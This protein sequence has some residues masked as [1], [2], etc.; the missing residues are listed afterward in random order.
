MDT[1]G[2]LLWGFMLETL[3]YGMSQKLRV[4]AKYH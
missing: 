1:I 3:L 4:I 2:A